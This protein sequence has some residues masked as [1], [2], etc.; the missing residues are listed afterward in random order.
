MATRTY[1]FCLEHITVMTSCYL[2]TLPCL[3]RAKILC[4][5]LFRPPTT[6]TIPITTFT[7][8]VFRSNTPSQSISYLLF[9]Q[10]MDLNVASVPRVMHGSKTQIPSSALGPRPL[11]TPATVLNPRVLDRE[12]DGKWID[13]TSDQRRLVNNDFPSERLTRRQWLRWHCSNWRWKHAV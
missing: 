8:T 11:V 5:S 3:L 10:R 7:F 6:I 1:Y 2:R 9:I 12:E 13:T 4:L